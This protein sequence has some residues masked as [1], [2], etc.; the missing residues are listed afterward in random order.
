MSRKKLD[1]DSYIE[2]TAEMNSEQEAKYREARGRR[3]KELELW[4]HWNDKGRKPEHV[5]PLMKSIEPLIRSETKKRMAGLGGSIPQA[6]IHNE[7]RNAALRSVQNYNPSRGTQL[8]THIVTGFQRISDFVAANRNERYMP[9]EHVDQYQTFQNTKAELAEELGR[10]PTIAELNAKFPSWS[11]ARVKKMNV[12]FGGELYTGMGTDFDDDP[13]RMR[14]R[15][16]FMLVKSQL[17][18][19][20]KHFGDLHFPETGKPHTIKNIAKQL[21]I[22]QDKAYRLKA[23]VERR[24]GGILKSE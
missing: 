18:E 10:E 12:G 20:E 1:V 21:G 23:R 3:G 2:K 16:A 11:P 17:T 5:E 6:A 8:T 19:Q 13:A 14:P 24:V 7:L 4:H 9:R 22:S 15:D